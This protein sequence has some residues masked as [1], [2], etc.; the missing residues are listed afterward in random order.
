[1]IRSVCMVDIRKCAWLYDVDG[2]NIFLETDVMMVWIHFSLFL[3]VRIRVFL[4]FEICFFL[5][6]VLNSVLKNGL[7]FEFD[8]MRYAYI[9]L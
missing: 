7:I 1:M 9:Y 8:S 6:N 5:K 3:C 2:I 4:F